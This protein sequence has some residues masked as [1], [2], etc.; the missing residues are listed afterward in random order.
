MTTSSKKNLAKFQDSADVHFENEALLALAFVHK[1]YV[2]EHPDEKGYNERL[3]FLGDAVLELSVTDFLYHNYPAQPEG[4]LTN[5]RSALVKGKN[6]ARVARTLNL[7]EY[8][9]LSRGEEIS[10]GREKDYILANTTE[11]LIGAIYLDKGFEVANQFILRNVV[12]MLNEIIAQG[13]NIDSKSRIQELAQEKLSITPSYEL[14][15]ET[16]PDHG[17][18][19]EMGIFFGKE[20]VEK[21]TG[22]SKQEAEQA[23]ARNALKAKGW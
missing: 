1:S 4:Q 17:K 21:G 9:Q 11:A 13:L 10:G 23:A 3:E 20:Q 22:P 14:L 16:G 19:F 18:I 12:A 6:L 7:G 5:W 8:L 2:N 15:S